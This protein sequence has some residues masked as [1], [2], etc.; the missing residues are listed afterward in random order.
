[1]CILIWIR[2]GGFLQYCADVNFARK[3]KASLKLA[4]AYLYDI[5]QCFILDLQPEGM[6]FDYALITLNLLVLLQCNGPKLCPW[7]LKNY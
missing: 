4:D 6:H 2:G 1:M 5:A 3:I 7:T